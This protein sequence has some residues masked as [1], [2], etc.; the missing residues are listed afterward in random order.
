MVLTHLLQ[1][2][3]CVVQSA[4]GNSMFSPAPCKFYSVNW[5]GLLHCNPADC[6]HKGEPFLRDVSKYGAEKQVLL[7]QKVVRLSWSCQDLNLCFWEVWCSNHMLISCC[8]F[9]NSVQGSL[10]IHR[11]FA[12]NTLVRFAL[13]FSSWFQKSQIKGCACMLHQLLNA[14]CGIH[15]MCTVL[16]KYCI[17]VFVHENDVFPLKCTCLLAPLWTLISEWLI[18][19]SYCP[20]V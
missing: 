2:S 19:D 10:M 6:S 5:F 4:V 8:R 9:G 12:N 20:A 18:F 13:A 15:G 17:S 1:S 7:Q 11:L 16:K 3:C 14:V